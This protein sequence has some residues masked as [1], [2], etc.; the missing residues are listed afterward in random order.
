MSIEMDE[1][2]KRWTARRKSALI[3]GIIQ[4]R[5]TVIESS[6][7]FDLPP[8]EI[9]SWTD[10]AKA[11]VEN[12]LK[13]KPEDIREQYETQLKV[14]QEAYRKAMLNLRTQKNGTPCWRRTTRYDP[15]HPVGPEGKP[16]YRSND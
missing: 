15:S 1:D 16:I 2:F 4:G 14:V 7:Q 13:A 11:G 9:K 10:Q 6:R 8:S 5:T 12:A 3:Q